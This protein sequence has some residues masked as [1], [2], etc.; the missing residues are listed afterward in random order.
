MILISARRRCCLFSASSSVLLVLLSAGLNSASAFQLNPSRNHEIRCR[1]SSSVVMDL[2]DKP[3]GVATCTTSTRLSMLQGNNG[4]SKDKKQNTKYGILST[5]SSLLLSLAVLATPLHSATAADTL[6]APPVADQGIGAI[7]ESSVGKSVRRSIVGGAKVA[8]NIDLKWER[9]S[10]S[11]RDKSKCDPVTNRR[12]FDN[13]T[14]RDGT[15]IGNPVLG[16][17]C[18][19]VP[20]RSV[21]ESTVSTVLGLAEQAAVD[22]LGQERA[23]LSQKVTS[24]RELV[25]PAFTRASGVVAEKVAAATDDGSADDKTKRQAYNMD[26]YTTMRAYGEVLESTKG[27]ANVKSTARQFD[28]VWGQ[29][30]LTTLAPKADRSDFRSPF[31]APDPTDEQPYDE[32]A[33]L[34]ALGA[35]SVTLDQ[36]Q[37]GGLIGHWEISI[38]EDDYGNVVTIAVDDDITIGAQMLIKEQQQQQPLSGSAVVALVRAAMDDRAKISYNMDT[39]FID[40]TTTKQ[41]LYDPTQLLVSLSNLGVS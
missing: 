21:S 28:R 30:M 22:V 31:P 33:L 41:E 14:R 4:E 36:L 25:G 34:D 5:V 23:V 17:L 11:L 6:F 35:V 8:D 3:S 24:V 13:G 20:L 10:D 19:P 40:P 2:W 15:K 27:S 26:V 16:A 18:D 37:Q 39:F 1:Q 7:T 32:N 9:F 29:K 38:P 12:L